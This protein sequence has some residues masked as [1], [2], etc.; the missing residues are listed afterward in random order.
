MRKPSG[1]EP[2]NDPPLDDP[3]LDDPPLDEEEPP[4][5]EPPLDEE[6]PPPDDDD[7]LLVLPEEPPDDEPPD[8]DPPTDEPAPRSPATAASSS[9]D[10][11]A[12]S[13]PVP[14]GDDVVVVAHAT[15]PKE[16][17]AMVKKKKERMSFLDLFAWQTFASVPFAPLPAALPPAAALH[18]E[19]LPLHSTSLSHAP[20]VSTRPVM[21]SSH[22]CVNASSDGLSSFEKPSDLAHLRLL[23][24]L[25]LGAAFVRRFAEPSD[26][27]RRLLRVVSDCLADLGVQLVGLHVEDL[28]RDVAERRALLL[29]RDE[30]VGRIDS[31]TLF[32][33]LP[34]SGLSIVPKPVMSMTGSVA[35][36]FTLS[37]WH[38]VIVLHDAGTT[39][40]RN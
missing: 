28:E 22:G 13:L 25:H 19:P 12:L 35:A 27:R 3:P 4:L 33:S 29:V 9:G 40:V 2:L 6:E 7:E 36:T 14:A 32:T 30:A 15:A 11:G 21:T 23:G 38:S 10:V 5:D 17:R 39:L 26:A 20:P 1:S 34:S 37:S 8:D 16:A 24:E 18:F 31:S